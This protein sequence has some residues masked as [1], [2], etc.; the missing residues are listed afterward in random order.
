MT[1]R[2]KEKDLAVPAMKLMA[3]H[4]NG[5]I[6]VGELIKKLED[7]LHPEGEDA[8]ILDG[9]NDTKLSQKIRNL[10]SHRDTSTSIIKKG[11]V[12]YSANDESLEITDLGKEYLK[13]RSD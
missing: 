2:I 13:N 7:T 12:N 4:A 1:K 10:V 11:Y 9:R 8:Q 6:R 3:E 5:K